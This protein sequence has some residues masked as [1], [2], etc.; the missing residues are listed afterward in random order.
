MAMPLPNS[1]GVSR[2]DGW[3]SA[4]PTGEAGARARA[5]A[6][7]QA[8]AAATPTT[9]LA[10]PST[11]SAESGGE[12]QSITVEQRVA[13][14]KGKLGAF[15]RTEKKSPE[16]KQQIKELKAEIQ[17]LEGGGKTEKPKSSS[18]IFSGISKMLKGGSANPS[19]AANYA[20]AAPP[21]PPAEARAQT[22]IGESP[23]PPAAHTVRAAPSSSQ[24]GPSFEA[25]VKQQESAYEVS[26][27]V[28]E[29]F[30]YKIDPDHKG[31]SIE[32]M[33]RIFAEVR[34]D[35]LQLIFVGVEKN[36]GKKVVEF[37]NATEYIFLR[38]TPDNKVKETVIT[39]NSNGEFIIGGG[40]PTKSFTEA[41]SNDPELRQALDTDMQRKRDAAAADYAKKGGDPEGRGDAENAGRLLNG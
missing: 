35:A 16:L 21:R 39:T 22:S 15:E 10:R 17:L 24:E 28:N 38:R 3:T 9:Q 33:K 1:T 25:S 2:A 20:A 37:V 30:M 31:R 27:N 4:A 32:T 26:K 11:S 23:K 18:S 6:I 8:N 12:T 7:T 36:T 13:G 41:L 29:G 14:L 34:D 40:K 5:G 19:S